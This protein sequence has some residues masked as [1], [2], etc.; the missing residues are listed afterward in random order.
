MLRFAI[1]SVVILLTFSCTCRAEG[2]SG[3]GVISSTY[4]RSTD[5]LFAV[6]KVGGD[7][8]NPDS[9]QSANQL[10]L[11]ND[12]PNRAEL[13]AALLSAGTSGKT[14]SAWLSGCVDWNGVT[15]PKIIG[16]NVFYHQ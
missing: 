3:E 15:Y 14:I 16:L 7:W 5:G 8:Q 4:L 11:T 10:V 1:L 13:Y 12:N 9:C 2:S 6:Y